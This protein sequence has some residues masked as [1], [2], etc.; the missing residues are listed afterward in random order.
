M[1]N[2]IG[3]NGGVVRASGNV[4]GI[5]KLDG[6]TVWRANTRDN[7]AVTDTVS[8]TTAG[9]TA[10]QVLEIIGKDYDAT[11]MKFM[12][13]VDGKWLVDAN[14]NEIIHYAAHASATEMNFGVYVKT[15]GGSGGETVLVDYI[16]AQQKR[17]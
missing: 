12:Y 16:L 13:K 3:D 15:G 17:V 6:G 5:Y 8:I 4:A 1:A 7:A 11:T 2:T 14:G 10:Y 9:G